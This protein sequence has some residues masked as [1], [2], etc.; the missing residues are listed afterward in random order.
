M[1]RQCINQYASL[2]QSE[3]QPSGLLA[4]N[5][6]ADFVCAFAFAFAF[7]MLPATFAPFGRLEVVTS[8]VLLILG[9]LV[10]SLRLWTRA[11][12]KKSFTAGDYWIIVAWLSAF[13]RHVIKLVVFSWFHLTPDRT[14][15]MDS[16]HVRQ[17]MK[18]LFITQ[19]FMLFSTGCVKLS[20]L[21]VY[22]E[23]FDV[24]VFAK[25]FVWFMIIFCLAMGVG[26]IIILLAMCK[27]L[28]SAYDPSIQGT[29]RIE[30]K[31]AAVSST[32][33]N[34]VTDIILVAIPLSVVWLMRL[35]LLKKMGVSLMFGLG[36]M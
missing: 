19:V 10:I 25:R 1:P 2:P 28:A 36:I 18:L 27:P 7:A 21:F 5:N 17:S 16:Y 23:L 26:N 12:R 24:I 20:I 31:S 4:C 11:I 30:L 9:L 15:S 8:T 22:L 33:I 3:T 6:R 32:V 29:Y 13:T 34:L 14:L 35:T